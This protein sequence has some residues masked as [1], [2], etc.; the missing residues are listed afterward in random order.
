MKRVLKRDCEA[1]HRELWGWLAKTGGDNKL[2]WHRWMHNGGDIPMSPESCFACTFAVTEYGYRDCKRCP[3]RW[4]DG[5]CLSMH[6]EY[7][8]WVNSYPSEERKRLAALIRDMPWN[9]RRGRE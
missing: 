8:L 6:S 1:L 2:H 9:P 7:V 4:T 3:L 5:R